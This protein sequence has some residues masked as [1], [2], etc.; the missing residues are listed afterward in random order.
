MLHIP[1]FPLHTVLFPGMPLYL[2]IFEPRYRLMTRL[3]LKNDTVFGVVSI[4]QGVEANGP[5]A[6][7]YQYGVTAR[8]KDVE[9]LKNGCLNITVVGE[10]RFRI[11]ELDTT[12]SYLTGQVESRPI[13]NPRPLDVLRGTRELRNQVE[14][15]LDLVSH[16]NP[17][18]PDLSMLDLPDDT[19]SLLFMA[20]SL[21]QLP[22]SE[23]QPLLEAETLTYLMHQLQ[24]L[25]RREIAILTP[26]ALVTEEDAKRASWLN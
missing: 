7:P 14:H 19:F 16:A 20:A 5:L 6:I 18:D 9:H 23:K 8:I 17:D 11:L 1:I 13:E 21:L 2:H 22:V 24:R 15:Y 3:C 10:D 4:K 25:Y 26:M 12:Q